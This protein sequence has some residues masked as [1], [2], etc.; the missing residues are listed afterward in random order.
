MHTTSPV[1]TALACCSCRVRT[2]WNGFQCSVAHVV[3][4]VGVVQIQWHGSDEEGHP[5]L[6]VHLA[7]M[8]DDC[9]SAE[10][11]QQAADAV[12]SQAS[13]QHVRNL[14]CWSCCHVLISQWCQLIDS[15]E[16]PCNSRC[17]GGW[18]Q[19]GIRDRAS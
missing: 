5:I 12:I 14:L 3:E 16:L 6:L 17:Q 18:M 11:A 13:S 4:A 1:S 8:C 19:L 9:Q 10:H 2:S 15:T 7:R